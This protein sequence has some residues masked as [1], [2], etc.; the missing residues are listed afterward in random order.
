MSVFS[1]KNLKP[2]TEPILTNNAVTKNHYSVIEF[3]TL[4]HPLCMC[5]RVRTHV[6]SIYFFHVSMNLTCYTYPRMSPRK[7]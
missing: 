4:S 1:S 7:K 3:M 2:L 6:L 5:L